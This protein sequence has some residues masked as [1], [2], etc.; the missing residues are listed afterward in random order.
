MDEESN[1]NEKIHENKLNLTIIPFSFRKSP[2]LSIS[3][4]S[5]DL[6]MAQYKL[7][8]ESD[9]E[10]TLKSPIISKLCETSIVPKFPI[11]FDNKEINYLNTTAYPKYIISLLDTKNEVKMSFNLNLLELSFLGKDLYTVTIYEYPMLILEFM[12]GNYTTIELFKKNN[13]LITG[14]DPDSINKENI[15]ENLKTGDFLENLPEIYSINDEDGWVNY[16]HNRMSSINKDMP[17]KNN[18]NVV[19]NEQADNGL[20]TS[21]LGM[22]KNIKNNRND[23]K[24]K[25]KKEKKKKNKSKKKGKNEVKEKKIDICT[26]QDYFGQYLEKILHFRDEL[27]IK[28]DKK[29]EN[30]KDANIVSKIDNYENIIKLLKRKEKINQIKKDILFYR[31]K[32]DEINNI[33]QKIK[34]II[35]NKQILL[36]ELNSKIKSYKTQYSE[37]AKNYNNL[38]PL[39]SRQ[40]LIYNSF[41]NRKMTEI[42]FV[43]FNKKIINLY[44]IPEFFTTSLKNENSDN[45]KKRFEFYNNNKKKISSM[46]GHITQLMIYMSKCFDIPLRYPLW[47]N[48]A[49]SFIIKDKKDKEKDFLPLHCDLKRD[50]KYINFENGLNY[51]KNDFKEIINF[52][53]IYEEIIPEYEYLTLNKDNEEY[54]FFNYFISFNHCLGDFVQNIQ[55]MYVK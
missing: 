30:K 40:N 53:A 29:M 22:N 43:F 55:N 10:S 38:L 19:N 28:K 35:A 45:T 50:D 21:S 18:P 37:L 17:Q 32:N 1:Q 7:K 33:K 8:I 11:D 12:D 39:L 26:F 20:G 31:N 47:L 24:E 25:E 48:G 27:Y 2:L 23:E 42:C 9:G 6:E 36:N 13:I 15:D 3:F 54:T 34:E 16:E 52:C 41:L 5:F 51:L 14:E 46:M 44:L 49:K 4:L